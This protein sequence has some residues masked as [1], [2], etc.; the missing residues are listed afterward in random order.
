M[1]NKT[2]TIGKGDSMIVSIVNN[3]IMSRS[4]TA[5]ELKT[6]GVKILEE[7]QSDDEEILI[8][9]RGK[10]KYAVL[11]I[12]YFNKLREQELESAYN[13]SLEDIKSGRYN[14]ES[15]EKHIKRIT[16]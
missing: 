14:E 8:N 6:R 13:D 9:V 3:T 4:I 1:N 12:S 7:L 5:N 2:L 11:P 15:V 10:I 16:K